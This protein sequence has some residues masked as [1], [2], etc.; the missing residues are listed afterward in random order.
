MN[1]R[2][3]IADTCDVTWERVRDGKIVMTTE[4][5][6]ASISQAVSEE[7]I[8]GGI[9]GGTV[10]LVSSQKEI[11]LAVRDALWTL[12]Y[13]EMSQGVEID[14]DGVATVPKKV[15]GEVTDNAGAFEVTIDD[16]NA[17]E[18]TIV[19]A[20]GKQEKVEFASGV[21]E[22]S[23][24]V[25]DGDKVVVYIKEDVTGDTVTFNSDKFS[26]A[27]KCTYRTIAYEPV[28]MKHV[29]DVIIQFD[30]VKPS[31]AFDLSFEMN[32]PIAPEMNF[33]VLT[34]QGTKEMGRILVTDPIDEDTP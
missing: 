4:S 22:T 14:P 19:G 25:E 30:S 27:Y 12:E 20:D 2:Y 34:P 5:Q 18:G 28:S 10:A 13:L 8:Y 1:S 16:Q 24:S 7:R 11:D 23:L 33:T 6:L 32:S 21:A 29:K 17:T 31:G 9:G 26:E 3:V 15:E